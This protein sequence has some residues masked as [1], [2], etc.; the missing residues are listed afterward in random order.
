M[1]TQSKRLEMTAGLLDSL[2]RLIRTSKVFRHHQSAEFGL[3]GTPFGILK[4][5]AEGDARPG[6]VALQLQIAPSVV[7]R[8]VVPLEQAQ[9]VERRTDPADARAWR[10]GLTDAGHR[11]LVQARQEFVDRLAPML[12]DWDGADIVTL[13]ELLARLDRT[14][15]RRLEPGLAPT[16]STTNPSTNEG[17]A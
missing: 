2:G 14:L 11:R 7:S 8:A 6:D 16:T 17:H 4:T 15:S 3:T 10:L 5:L 1:Q 13:T 12:D 9:L